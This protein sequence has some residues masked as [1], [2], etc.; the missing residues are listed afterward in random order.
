ML[1]VMYQAPKGLISRTKMILLPV[2]GSRDSGRAASVA[3]ELSHMTGAK[4]LIIHVINAGAVQQ[5]AKMSGT[6]PIVVL[7]QYI[8]NGRNLLERYRNA[9]SEYGLDIELILEKGLPSDKIVQVAKQKRV[10]VIVIGSAGL[11]NESRGA[12]GSTTER[13]VRNADCAILVIKSPD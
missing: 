2:D 4:L 8:E 11:A 13:V 6:D 1:D 5:V 10:D 7:N 3:F 12:V 9:A